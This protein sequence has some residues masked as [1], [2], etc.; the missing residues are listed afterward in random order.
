M[1]EGVVDTRAL[2]EAVT[3]AGSCAGR[4]QR[5]PRTGVVRAAPS[6]PALLPEGRAPALAAAAPDMNSL[7]VLG[8]CRKGAAYAYSVSP[9]SCPAPQCCRPAPDNVYFEAAA[10]IVTLILLGRCF[11]ARAKG[12][13]SEAIK[14]LMGCRPKTARVERD[15]AGERSLEAGHARRRRR[16]SV[17]ARRSRRRRGAVRGLVLRRRGHDHRRAG[18]G[19]EDRGPRSSAARSTR[20]AASPS[21]PTK[22]GADTVLAQIIRMVEQ[23]QGAKLPIQALVDKVTAGSCPPSWRQRGA[24]LPRLAGLRPRARADLRAGQCG[25]GADHRLPLRH[26]PGD[27]DLDHGRHRSRRRVRRPVPQG[28]GAAGAEGASRS[29]PSTRP[30]P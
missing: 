6:G 16:R 25:C 4:D 2:I 23:A 14:R 17:P 22:V 8:G 13:T 9:P 11:E 5:G 26:G 29:S 3:Q 28:R 21:A 20:P 27:A 10:V 15:G 12:R 1:L 18:P 7:V 30:A 19:R 24:D